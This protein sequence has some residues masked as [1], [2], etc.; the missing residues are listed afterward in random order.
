MA[1]RAGIKPKEEVPKAAGGPEEGDKLNQLPREREGGVG[2]KKEQQC[3]M[4]KDHVKLINLKEIFF[5]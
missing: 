5:G 4:S 2:E 3:T 1:C